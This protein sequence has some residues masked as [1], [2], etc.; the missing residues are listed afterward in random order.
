MWVSQLGHEL[1]FLCLVIGYVFHGMNADIHTYLSQ[2]K[3]K[4]IFFFFC[5]GLL[6]YHAIQVLDFTLQF[7]TVTWAPPTG[8]K[9]PDH[10]A[11][12][13][14]V[15]ASILGIYGPM[16]VNLTAQS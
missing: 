2:T 1:A 8:I 7:C 9:S 10:D 14:G 4:Y 11:Q 12:I 15:W 13:A 3:P 16:V 5:H 6:G